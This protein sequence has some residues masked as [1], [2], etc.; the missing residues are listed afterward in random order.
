M[1]FKRNNYDLLNLGGPALKLTIIRLSTF[2]H[3]QESTMK[4]VND[5]NNE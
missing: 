5:N 4:E 2:G 3:L 1:P